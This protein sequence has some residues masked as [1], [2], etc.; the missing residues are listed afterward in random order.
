MIM[1]KVTA[2]VIDLCP[3]CAGSKRAVKEFIAEDDRYA[4]VDIDWINEKEHPEI[5]EEYDYYYC[6]AFFVD[7]KKI[8][9]AHP[10]EE[11]DSIRENVNRVLDAALEA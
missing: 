7:G 11:Y 3:Y 5:T 6:P 4:A 8:Y 9:E 2:F 10:G 1:K